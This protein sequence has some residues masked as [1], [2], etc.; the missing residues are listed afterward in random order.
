MPTDSSGQQWRRW[1]DVLRPRHLKKSSATK[2]KTR[3]IL[4]LSDIYS[5]LLRRKGQI[6]RSCALTVVPDNIKMQKQKLARGSYA[7][8]W[9]MLCSSWRELWPPCSPPS[10]WPLCQIPGWFCPHRRC[11]PTWWVC[12]AAAAGPWSRSDKWSR[13]CGPTQSET[14]NK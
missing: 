8:A 10:T 7:A 9:M 2:V 11:P 1:V 4:A 12:L 13:V 14:H 6:K 5:L 3:N